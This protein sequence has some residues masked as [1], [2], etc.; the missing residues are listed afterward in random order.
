M[1][2]WRK[3]EKI[4][5]Y[6]AYTLLFVMMIPIVYIL[7][8]SSGKSLIWKQDG[9]LQHYVALSYFGKWGREVLKNIFLLH[10]FQIPLW[11]FHVGYG[12][13]VITTF[14]YYV[15][16]DP[17]NLISIAV[18]AKYSEYLYD[19]LILLRM[20][21]SGA[22]FSYFCFERKK[23]KKAVLAGAMGYVFC[24]AVI[25]GAVCHPF[26]INPMIYLPLLLVGAERIFR[27]ERPTLFILM[28]F[29]SA[30]S[31]FYFFYTIAF[32]VCFYVCVRFFTFR[33]KYEFKE[34]CIVIGRFF[35]YA[36]VGMLMSAVILI[37]VVMQFM[38]TDRMKADQS[39]PV[40]Y[41][42]S[43]YKKFMM[44]FLAAGSLERRTNLGFTAPALLAVFVL[45]GKKKQ[46][47][48]LKASFFI[49][50]AML[51]IPVFGKVLNGFSYISNRW[52]WIYAALVSYIL[53]T[54]WEDMLIYKNTSVKFVVI[55]G[56]IYIAG[57][58]AVGTKGHEVW[59]GILFLFAVLFPLFVA[60]FWNNKNSIRFASF[61]FLCVML[62]HI[63]LNWFG[64]F[65]LPGKNNKSNYVTAKTAWE[66]IITSSAFAMRQVALEEKNFFR[67]DRDDFN[68]SRNTAA[69]AG[70]NGL[71]YYWSLENGSIAEYLADMDMRRFRSY[72]YTDLDGRV[73][74]NAI[75]GVKYYVRSKKRKAVPFG[76]QYKEKVVLGAREY[77]IYKNK[78]AL[79]LGVLYSSYI[80]REEY[81]DMKPI[82]RQEAMMQGVVID[83][84]ELPVKDFPKT[85]PDFTS[86]SLNYKIEC[87]KN[88]EIRPD[89]SFLV[90]KKGGRA[91]LKFSAPGKCEIYLWFQGVNIKSKDVREN[92]FIMNINS[93]SAKT[94]WRY[95]DKTHRLYSGQKDFL[96][97]LGYHETASSSVAVRFNQ[98]GTYRFED[99][100]LIC[101]PMETYARQAETLRSC[102]L[103]HEEIGINMVKGT[104]NLPKQQMLFLSIPY[105]SGW[106]ALV[107]GEKTPLIKANVMF[108]ALPLEGGEHDIELYYRTPGLYLGIVISCVG[109][110]V[111]A[112]TILCHKK[113]K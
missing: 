45:F 77:H 11:D 26:F 65:Y 4:R 9:F 15:I 24:G 93:D 50:T 49:M 53:V 13:D 48:A 23:G 71:D 43:Y 83:E 111:F 96:V 33:Q 89:G 25:Y 75:A 106:K 16:G 88:V 28:V 91:K 2:Q 27:G 100:K 59:I 35:C 30:V 10:N 74:L 39:I 47:S 42:L 37:P 38:Q 18:P 76:Y 73:S 20:Y 12:S 68:F 22:S 58:F 82:E 67:F 99:M 6:A 90:K 110:L 17:L 69:L 63:G 46:H 104:V 72:N 52:S 81:E 84:Q 64:I 109:F 8:F 102:K 103:E 21:L 7:L 108:M 95:T 5:Y 92:E 101:Q 79:P 113:K 14:H 32:A 87:D 44:R 85:N 80:P 66:K 60:R 112:A 3:S 62:L 54:V 40:L 98:K 36:C 86:R 57:Y 51:W 29:L 61:V 70:V 78:Y 41:Q 31:N 105:S 97:N 1:A 55:G 94:S 19:A 56:L 34:F 107:D